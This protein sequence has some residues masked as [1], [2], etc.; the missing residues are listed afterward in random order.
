MITNRL[1]RP[2]L[3][4][5]LIIFS[6]QPALA[7]ANQPGTPTRQSTSQTSAQP[8]TPAR[9]PDPASGR[10]SSSA[11]FKAP[12]N[13]D[14]RVANV[15][16]EGVRLHAELFSLKALAGKPLPTII[17]AHGWGGTAANF[18][19]DKEVCR[20]SQHHALWRL[21]PGTRASHQ[22]GHRMV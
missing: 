6:V 4:I 11:E 15:M 9:P 17:M 12:D 10:P 18:R 1:A 7:Q 21:L 2:L 13:M 14:F 20:H 16:S 5:I 22:A 3:V 8:A 19:R